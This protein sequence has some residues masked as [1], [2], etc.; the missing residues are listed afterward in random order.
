MN[1]FDFVCSRDWGHCT[2]DEPSDHDYE[3]PAMPPGVM[4]DVDHQCR[5]QFGPDAEYCEGIDVS[6]DYGRSGEKSNFIKY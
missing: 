1:T 2:D 6:T 3:Y 4:Y 5:L